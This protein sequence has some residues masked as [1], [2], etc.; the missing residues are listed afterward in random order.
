MPQLLRCSL[1]LLS[2]LAGCL[3]RF[4]DLRTPRE[5]PLQLLD[6]AERPLQLGLLFPLYAMRF[7]VVGDPG[8]TFDLPDKLI[9]ALCESGVLGSESLYLRAGVAQLPQTVAADARRFEVGVAR[10][11]RACDASLDRLQ[12]GSGFFERFETGGYMKFGADPHLAQLAPAVQIRSHSLELLTGSFG[13]HGELFGL[14]GLSGGAAADRGRLP[15]QGVGD[16]RLLPTLELPVA[17]GTVLLRATVDG[18]PGLVHVPGLLLVGVDPS[19]VMRR[20]LPQL[21]LLFAQL[22]LRPLQVLAA[23]EGFEILREPGGFFPHR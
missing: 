16:L 22:P 11:L 2:L 20:E 7:G 15:L 23:R 18:L 6:P 3:Q 12:V 17:G 14:F 4:L 1:R 8:E 5:A 19:P 9:D 13:R 21:V 10:S